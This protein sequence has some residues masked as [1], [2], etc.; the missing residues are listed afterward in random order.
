VVE[1]GGVLAHQVVHGYWLAVQA[2]G[3]PGD[4]VEAKERLGPVED[5]ELE[6]RHRPLTCEFAWCAWQC[7]VS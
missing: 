7:L 6:Q 5:V 3:V 1:H 4:R 2:H